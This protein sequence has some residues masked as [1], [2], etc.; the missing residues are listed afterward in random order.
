MND[1][2]KNARLFVAFR[3]LFNA[4]FY[5]PVLAVL[6]LDLGLTIDQY[7]LLNVAWAVSIVLCELPLVVLLLQRVCQTHVFALEFALLLEDLEEELEVEGGVLAVLLLGLSRHPEGE[8]AQLLEAVV[9]DVRVD[10][11]KRGG[12]E[13]ED[14]E[15]HERAHARNLAEDRPFRRREAKGER[16]WV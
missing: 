13:G 1:L 9:V 8:H 7:A 6:F 4:R 2:P 14:Q 5:Y 16:L 10:V 3:V 15:E 12:R 11:P